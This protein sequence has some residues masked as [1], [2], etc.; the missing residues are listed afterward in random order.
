[1]SHIRKSIINLTI[2]TA[3]LLPFAACKKWLDQKPDQ[4]MVII[5][6]LSDE[7]SL[8]DYY[9]FVNKGFAIGEAASDNFYVTDA[10]YAIVPDYEKNLYKWNPDH[11]FA[12]NGS[13]NAWS[14]HYD[15]VYR[16]NTVLFNL[17]KI[18]RT[19]N[20]GSDFNNVRGQAFFLRAKSFL[21]IA[22]IWSLAYD[23]ATA[24][25]DLGIPLRLDP[26]FNAPTT[27]STNEQTYQQIVGD[28]KQAVALLPAS[29]VSV[30]RPSQGAAC[31]LL[32][33]TYLFM[34]QYDSCYRYAS[35][36]LAMKSNLIDFNTL[37]TGSTYPFASIPFTTNPEIIYYDNVA[38]P[39]LLSSS[40]AKVDT[41]LFQSYSTGD[42]RKT[43]F[44]KANSNGSYFFRGS[45][46]GSGL[47]DG[48]ATSELFLMHAECA[49]RS[50]D[51]TTAM[52]DLNT[53]LYKRW[54]TGLFVPFTAS[55]PA[56]GLALVLTERRK[57]LIFRDMRWMD[58]KRFN[59]EGAAITP[60]RILSGS[61]YTLSPNDLRYAMA[62][63]ED[64]IALSGIAPNPR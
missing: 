16:A 39:S 20:D 56:Q 62:I 11:V 18:T 23:P 9:S 45:Y 28:L 63:P 54:K 43:V 12:I 25:T 2:L 64:I 14:R 40:K 34:R 5:T 4:K 27:R 53:L 44:F 21:A 30:T 51:I 26:D 15:N 55:T 33:R 22:A 29:Q 57:E 31:A 50:G 35:L 47:F 49:A 24:N 6:T 52:N 42:L 3:L 7:Q 59:K 13:A 61:S 8:L 46:L 19:P 48:I 17:E 10:D 36:A 1:M 60:Q 38:A 32:A 58:I 41:A 37:S